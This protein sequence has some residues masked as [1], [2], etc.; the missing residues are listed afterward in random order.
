[1]RNCNVAHLRNQIELRCMRGSLMLVCR[2]MSCSWLKSLEVCMQNQQLRH[3]AMF[4][5]MLL[6]CIWALF[7][8][9]CYDMW[10]DELHLCRL[11]GCHGMLC[12]WLCQ[13][14]V[15]LHL[16][17]ED[18]SLHW[19]FHTYED[20]MEHVKGIYFPLN[21]N[22]LQCIPYDHIDDRAGDLEAFERLLKRIWLLLKAFPCLPGPSFAFTP[23]KWKVA[24]QNTSINKGH[25]G[26][27]RPQ[28]P[29]R[30]PEHLRPPKT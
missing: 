17:V 18:K 16:G 5:L 6:W 22:I 12:E 11:Q 23:L 24:G 19:L 2:T 13:Y 9:V 28:R 4:G 7:W 21:W 3:L 27:I 29:Q 25:K 14:V 30:R 15:H 26:P 10:S 8:S 20:L 1:M